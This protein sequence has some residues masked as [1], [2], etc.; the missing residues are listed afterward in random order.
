MENLVLIVSTVL[1]ILAIKAHAKTQVN[2]VKKEDK[3]WYERLF[4]GSRPNVKNLTD[5]G[6][7]Y[8]RQS[9]LYAITGLLLLSL[10]VWLRSM[11]G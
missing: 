11:A 7:K 4:S 6:L 5:E 8:R 10:Y 3:V 2:V 1:L 9:N